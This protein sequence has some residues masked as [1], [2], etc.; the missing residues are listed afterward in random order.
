MERHLCSWWHFV[1]TLEPWLWTTAGTERPGVPLLRVLEGFGSSAPCSGTERWESLLQAVLGEYKES[2]ILDP[3]VSCS[4]HLL[5]SFST[6]TCPVLMSARYHAAC[7]GHRAGQDMESLPTGSSSSS[8]C[9]GYQLSKSLWAYSQLCSLK[10]I[11]NPKAPIIQ[12][13]Q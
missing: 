4:E 5:M 1:P 3:T 13:H 6:S 8:K 2:G 10:S 9:R 12:K 11:N 7:W